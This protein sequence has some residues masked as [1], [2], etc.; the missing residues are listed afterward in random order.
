M[1]D[2]PGQ[3]VRTALREETKTVVADRVT[4]VLCLGAVTV[5]L[6]IPIDRNFGPSLWLELA[7]IKVGIT[8]TYALA[9]LAVHAARR[10]AWR[11]AVTIATAA[12]TLPCFGT[13]LITWCSGDVLMQTYVLTILTIGGAM[14]FPWGIAA[15]SAV[16]AVATLCLLPNVASA[17][18]NLVFATFSAFAASIYAAFL[19][20]RERL[21]RKAVEVLRSG[22]EHALELVATDADLPHVLQQLLRS[23]EQ[24]IPEAQ[25][26]VLLVDDETHR[27]RLV[28]AN[29]LPDGYCRR[30]DGLPLDEPTPYSTAVTSR[31]R[32]VLVLTAAG[33]PAEG[34]AS[35]ARAYGLCVCLCEPILSADGSAL[36]VLGVHYT[37]PTPPTA[38]EIELTAATVRLAT[39]AIE[40]RAAR[41]QLGRYLQS[42]DAARGQAEQQ[43]QQLQEQA[44][45]LAEARDQALALT[46][47][48]SEFLANMSHE[49]RTPLN[50][51]LGM[52][53]ILLDAGLSPEQHEHASIVRRCGEH[54]LTVIN[55]ILDSSKIE[56][57]KLVIEHVDFELTDVIEEVA[58]LLAAPAHEKELELLCAIPADLQGSVRGDP[59]RIRQILT[60]LVSNAIKFTE[61]G[62]VLIAAQLV[63][64]TDTQLSVRLS[65]R[66][67][68]I[69]IPRERHAAIFESF[70][71]ADGSTTR[72][73]G[74][75]GLGL[76]ISR[77][78]VELM[79]GRI[80][81]ESTNGVGSTFWF[82]LSLEKATRRSRQSRTSTVL[83]GLPVLV[84]DDNATSRV[85]LQEILHAWGCRVAAVPSG[86]AAVEALQEAAG[87]DPFRLVILDFDMPD[88]DGQQTA[89]LIRA[90]PRLDAMPLILLSSIG[91]LPETRQMGFS[92]VL[93]KPVRQLILMDTTLAVLGEHGDGARGVVA[94]TAV[95]PLA[96]GLRVLLAEDNRVNRTVALR[97]LAKLGCHVDTVETGR[98]AIEAVGR[99]AY[100][101]VLMDVQMPIVDGFEAAVEI[102]RRE[103]GGRRLP[104]IALTAHAMEGDRARCLQAG[105]DDY[106]SKPVTRAALAAKLQRWTAANSDDR[107]ASAAAPG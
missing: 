101:I 13:A 65:V 4:G 14:V 72:K 100:D 106:L 36:G 16:V 11:Y 22:H 104:I 96:N 88:L 47:T 94:G 2:I 12:A 1:R 60:N 99:A 7:L 68:G 6:S 32:S 18:P 91:R 43:A 58:Q 105:M 67:T 28:A 55:D 76:T 39:V 74:G 84:V 23:V 86:S 64:E 34:I 93:T 78:L 81:L 61:H 77:Q 38:R 31:E 107:I 95:P 37:E 92:A 21:E 35:C 46:R 70:T 57:G 24:Q 40:R 52:T 17:A 5:I 75:T 44:H 54:L 29:R 97:L 19:F 42:L 66:D 71:Q 20:E 25:C 90:L 49:I 73:Y 27:L 62:E 87:K 51:I 59:A 45:Q 50:G 56:A 48:K 30:V 10:A 85:I 103:N 26:A 79:G 53:D 102:R 15:Q 8:I 63:A 82:E 69:G 41:E 80:G 33:V 98:D 3:Y 9:A 83:A 89:A